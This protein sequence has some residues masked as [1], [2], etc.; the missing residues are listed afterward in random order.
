[1]RVFILFVCLVVCLATLIRAFPMPDY[2]LIKQQE[3]AECTTSMDYIY[4][5][6]Y[7][8]T[9]NTGC[10]PFLGSLRAPCET[11]ND[12]QFGLSCRQDMQITPEDI[13]KHIDAGGLHSEKVNVTILRG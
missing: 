13:K 3:G 7:R 6:Y 5:E 11:D 12:C 2:L 8:C 10:Q 9:N 1:M 4:Q